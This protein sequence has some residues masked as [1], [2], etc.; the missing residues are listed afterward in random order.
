LRFNGPFFST[1]A[2]DLN[3]LES[4]V[5]NQKLEEDI[6]DV[7]EFLY[8]ARMCHLPRKHPDELFSLATRLGY[9]DPDGHLTRKG[10]G[11]LERQN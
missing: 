1:E 4:P 6:A 10:R 3:T 9:I 11:L 2:N 5:I 8:G 7:L